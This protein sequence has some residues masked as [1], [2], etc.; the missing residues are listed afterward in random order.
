MPLSLAEYVDKRLGA[1]ALPLTSTGTLNIARGVAIPRNPNRLFCVFVNLSAN[2]MYLNPVGAPSNTNGV[3]IGA[4]GGS[5]TLLAEEDFDM[6]GYEWDGIAAA[7]ASSFF[8]LE[9]VTR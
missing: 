9:G 7:D 1:Q 4:L 8:L 3:L 5:L 6:T 2:S